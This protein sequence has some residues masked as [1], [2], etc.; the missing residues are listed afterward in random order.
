VI[1]GLIG[2]GFA[3][4]YHFNIIAPITAVWTAFFIMPWIFKYSDSEV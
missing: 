1:I 3:L 2:G 4:N